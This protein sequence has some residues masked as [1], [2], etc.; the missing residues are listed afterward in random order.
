[1]EESN[2]QQDINQPASSPLPSIPHKVNNKVVFVIAGLIL[3]IFISSSVYVL[4]AR[5]SKSPTQMT[6]TSTSIPTLTP[7]ETPVQ[8]ITVTLTQPPAITN[9]ACGGPRAVEQNEG[10]PTGYHCGAI[11]TVG[12]ETSGRCIKN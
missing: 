3:L 12:G 6:N 4:N 2:V 10:C 9:I 1:M 11:Q 8:T 7:T 5:K